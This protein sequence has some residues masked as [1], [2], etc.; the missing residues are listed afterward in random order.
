MEATLDIVRRC[1]VRDRS[2]AVVP[3]RTPAIHHALRLL[4]RPVFRAYFGMRGEGV[5]HLPPHGPFLIAPNHVSMLDWAFISYFLPW[6]VRFVVHREY[7]DHAVLG[8]TLRWNG[9][10]PIRTNGPDPLA[11]RLA[12]AVLASG[13]PL[14]IFPEGGI[15]R[16]GRPQRAQPGVVSIASASRVPIVPVAIRGAFDAFP[17]WR[18]YPRPGR[19]TLVFGRPL[20]PPPEVAGRGAQQAQADALMAH[21]TALLD[22][23]EARAPW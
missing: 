16:T 10:V 18:R 4:L 5:Q 23:R 21:I 8:R 13:E 20:A 14:I 11:I 22:G 12:H 7:W 3:A 6:Q 15:S 17:R 1:R 9:A 2:A 19:V